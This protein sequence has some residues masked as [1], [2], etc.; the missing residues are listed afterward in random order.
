MVVQKDNIIKDKIPKEVSGK[1]Q[2]YPKDVQVRLQ[3]L[4]VLIL[5]T[6]AKTEGVGKIEECLK[7][8]EPSF[9]TSQ[10]GSGTPIRIDWKVKDPERCYIYFH[11]QTKMISLIK[12]LYPTDFIYHGNRALSLNLKS[13]LPKRKL[14][15]CFEI[16]LTYH[17]KNYKDGLH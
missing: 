2:T 3:E 16:A 17:F 6:A 1:I 15:M 14:V 9:L 11:C 8:G 12:E 10:S 7:W 13:R 4:R 5:E